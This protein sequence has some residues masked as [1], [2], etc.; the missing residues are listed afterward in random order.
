MKNLQSVDLAPA[1]YLV[2]TPIGNLR[3]MSIRA[4]DIL[5]RVDI[6]LCEDSRVT[7]KLLKAHDIGGKKLIVYN[8]HSD[9]KKRRT[10]LDQL[11]SGGRIALVSDAGTP[12]ISDP[13]YKLVRDAQDLGLTVTSVPGANAP[14]TA[15][16][17]S[18]LPTD[19]FSFI[20]FLPAKSIARCKVLEEW[21]NVPGTLVLFE[22]GLRLSDSLKDM[23]DVLGDREVAVVRELTKLYEQ[24]RREKLSA[25]ISL[26]EAEGAPKGEIV[27]VIGA[28]HKKVFDDSELADKLQ[29]A[30]KTMRVKEAASFV[31]GMTGQPKK[32]LYELA[33]SLKHKN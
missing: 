2:S 13:G 9:D 11:S 17:L 29:A 3:D 7:G 16:Q 21:K 12:L 5:R 31:A 27:V 28:A 30:M 1:L 6:I 23:L 24:V 15:L 8:D 22:S 26:Y 4:I 20:G 14:L 19:R 32:K 18:G 33:L 25:L 10:I